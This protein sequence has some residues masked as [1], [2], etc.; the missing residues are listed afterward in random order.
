VPD[1]TLTGD[2]VAY[3]KTSGLPSTSSS[4]SPPT[5][6]STPEAE[7]EILLRVL[8]ELAKVTDGH[9]RIRKMIKDHFEKLGN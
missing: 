2:E 3:G 8:D 6:N 7:T 5:S 4:G 1:A 9:E